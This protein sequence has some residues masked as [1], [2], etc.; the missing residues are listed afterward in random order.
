MD[1][2]DLGILIVIDRRN[3]IGQ[4]CILST[5]DSDLIAEMGWLKAKDL[6]NRLNKLKELGHLTT[7][8]SLYETTWSITDKGKRLV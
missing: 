4:S 5:I 6:V 2:W 3:S 8:K 7:V 1:G